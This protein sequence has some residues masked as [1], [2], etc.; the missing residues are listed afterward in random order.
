METSLVNTENPDELKL[1][2]FSSTNTVI[3]EKDPKLEIEG[4]FIIK[5]EEYVIVAIEI[6][7]IENHQYFYIYQTTVH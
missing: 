2:H 4:R 3:T 1:P 6:D 7:E 5:D